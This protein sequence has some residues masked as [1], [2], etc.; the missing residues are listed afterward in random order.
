MPNIRNASKQQVSN[1]IADSLIEKRENP[2]DWDAISNLAYQWHE[3]KRADWTEDKNRSL[4]Q[5]AK[6]AKEENPEAENLSALLEPVP[7]VNQEDI[8]DLIEYLKSEGGIFES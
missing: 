4:K 3:F 8:E 2:T 5:I 1:E 6:K 7:Y